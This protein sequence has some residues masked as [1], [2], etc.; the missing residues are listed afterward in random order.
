MSTN[1]YIT[2]PP[3]RLADL[4]VAFLYLP[5]LLLY[6]YP[7]ATDLSHPFAAIGDYLLITYGLAW[8][9]HAL[10][11]APAH[12]FDAN[13]MFPAD[14]SLAIATPLNSSQLLFFAPALELGGDPILAINFVYLGNILATALSCYYIFRRYRAGRDAAFVGGWIFA[15]AIGKMFQ[16]F[17]FPF[18]WMPWAFHLWHRFLLEN[19]WRHLLAAALC[20]VLLSLGSFYLMFMSFLGLVAWTTVFH[21]KIRSLLNRRFLLRALI[22]GGLVGLLLLPFGWPYFSVSRT[23]GLSRPM[24]EVIQYSADPLSSYLL[25]DNRSVLY[26]RLRWGARY[27]P[28]PGEERLFAAVFSLVQKAAGASVLGDRYSEGL[29][30]RDFHG[31]WAVGGEERR[32]F[33][34]YSVLSLVALGLLGRVPGKR[35]RERI[36]LAWLALIM[37][38]LSLGPVVI[39]LGHLTYVPGPYTLFYYLLPGLKGMRATARFGYVAMLAAAAL[40]V[41]GWSDLRERVARMCRARNLPASPAIA[42]LLLGWLGLF[43]LENLPAERHQHPRPAD[44]PG[45][46]AWLASQTIQ[47]GIIEIP[48]FKGSMKKTD[49]LYGARRTAYSQ[50]EYLYMYYSIYHWQPIYN[51]FG[52]FISPL[53]FQ[54]RDAVERLPDSRAVDFLKRQGL[55]TLVLHRYWFE[56]EDER[57]WNRADVRQVL[58]VVVETDGAEV[59][60]LR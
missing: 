10:L 12:F 41:Y 3:L 16:N 11:H 43:T 36:L 59:C 30:Y 58:K 19:R 22:G 9:W 20:F 51:G 5:G 17:Q 28:L 26:D 33:L 40:S 42:L 2:G 48:T 46:Y 18:F 53:Q 45:G 4:G 47:G 60:R 31:I 34:G 37:A 25:P 24:G 27:S 21:W 1:G 50:R 35:R 29:A 8:Q 15:F 23:Y 49:P 14:G 44:P 52:A 13:V 39:L 57:F 55:N 38:I 6:T 54:I 7:L 56:P 32:L